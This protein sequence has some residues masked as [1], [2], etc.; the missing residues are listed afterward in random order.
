[1]F[2]KILTLS[3]IQNHIREAFMTLESFGLSQPFLSSQFYEDEMQK[4]GLHLYR[5]D[6]GGFLL[7]NNSCF[8]QEEG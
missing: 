2:F 5:V 8:V 1:M 7:W 4:S 6:P 3:A